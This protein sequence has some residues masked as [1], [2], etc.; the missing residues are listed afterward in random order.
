M[1]KYRNMLLM[2]II[3]VKI[4]K[5][6]FLKIKIWLTKV[7]TVNVQFELIWLYTVYIVIIR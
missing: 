2:A 4:R 3:I 6:S 5:N 7:F 1:S